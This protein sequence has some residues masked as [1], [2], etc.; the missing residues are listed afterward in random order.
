MERYMN[1]ERNETRCKARTKAGKPCRAAATGGGL[2]FFHANP[3]KAS[4]LGRIGGRKNRHTAAGGVDA[5]P[6]SDN[7]IA[8]R[9]NLARW[10]AELY[11]GKLSP[12]TARGLA[13]L[14]TL[15]LRVI[16]TADLERR[17]AMLEKKSSAVTDPA[18]PPDADGVGGKGDPETET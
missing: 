5:L 3:N 11:S 18:E 17:L 15:Q 4:E 6:A 14:L 1:T 2:C 16:E 10:A 13:S 9:H 12:G 8:V 7:A